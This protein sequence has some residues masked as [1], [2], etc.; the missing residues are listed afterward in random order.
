MFTRRIP[1]SHFPKKHRSFRPDA[2]WLGAERSAI[3]RAQKV[4]A[5]CA[6]TWWYSMQR[7]PL[8]SKGT[9]Q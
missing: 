1:F 6:L 7:L 3:G 9:K 8:G 5:S 4:G 2:E